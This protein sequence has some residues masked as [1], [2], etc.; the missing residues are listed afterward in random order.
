MAKITNS[1][2]KLVC[3]LIRR[4]DRIIVNI[5]DKK[6]IGKTIKGKNNQIEITEEY[7]GKD[8][9]SS[10]EAIELMNSSNTLNLI[11][12]ETIKIANKEK[13]GAI[14]AIKKI[15]KVPFLMVF[16]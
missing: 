6:L 9:V 10:E 11:G 13:V 1:E 16:Q 7:F 15:G 14:G 2:K 4:E 8:E 12:E 3:R 5:C